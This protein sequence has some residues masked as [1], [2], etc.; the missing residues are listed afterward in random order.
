MLV[1]G[2]EEEPGSSC[3]RKTRRQEECG[4]TDEEDKSRPAETNRQQCGKGTMGKEGKQCLSLPPDFKLLSPGVVFDL[5][6]D[7][8]DSKF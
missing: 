4:S 3:S 2:Q 8:R 6:W 1:Y 5:G 7:P